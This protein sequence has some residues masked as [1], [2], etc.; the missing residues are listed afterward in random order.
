MM[1]IWSKIGIGIAFALIIAYFVCAVAIV[2]TMRNEQT[3]KDLQLVIT[4][5]CSRQFVDATEIRQLL[6]DQNMYPIGR[7]M[8]EVSLTSIETAIQHHPTLRTTECYSTPYGTVVVRM[9]QRKPV[10]RVMS[11][12]RN[13]F[14]DSD[15]Q[16]LSP[17]SK[18]ASYVPIITGKVTPQMATGELFDFVCFLEKNEYWDS[19]IVQINIRPDCQIELIPRIGN[20]TILLGSLT[21]YEHKLAKLQKLYVDGFNKIGWQTYSTLDL[22]F[23][24][25]IVAKK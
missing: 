7:P 22:R 18:T 20:Q 14:V 21:N 17:R 1:S 23:N 12:D 8:S 2:P 10:L 9:S 13:Y 4:D 5:S 25:Q 24:G 6:V 15:R 19:Q 11:D 3:C 16:I